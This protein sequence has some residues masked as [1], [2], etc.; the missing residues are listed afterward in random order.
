MCFGWLK[1]SV[2]GFGGCDSA[3]AKL[4]AVSGKWEL[5]LSL[6]S[7]TLDL[8]KYNFVLLHSSKGT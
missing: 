1:R 4:L 3:V 5:K 2:D 7:F 8:R 6:N